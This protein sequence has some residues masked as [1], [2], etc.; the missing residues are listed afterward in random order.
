MWFRAF[1]NKRCVYVEEP[2]IKWRYHSG[3]DSVTDKRHIKNQEE[4]HLGFY[5]SLNDNEI[6]RFFGSRYNFYYEM[7]LWNKSSSFNEL[8]NLNVQKFRDCEEP[9]NSSELRQ[10]FKSYLFSFGKLNANKLLIFGAGERGINLLKQLQSRKISVDCFLDNNKVGQIGDIPCVK[11]TKDIVKDS[12]IIVTPSDIDGS[13]KSQLLLLGSN[14]WISY[15][16][17]IRNL[18]EIPCIK[19]ETAL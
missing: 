16:D 8:F 11:P 1:R 4:L 13:I 12:V 15:D 3:Q 18:R 7:A 10:I 5:N 2:L 14:S 19:K 9:Q 17:V 6:V